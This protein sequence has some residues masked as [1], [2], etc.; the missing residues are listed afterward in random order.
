MEFL[1]QLMAELFTDEPVTGEAINMAEIQ[2]NEVVSVE[3]TEIQ[4]ITEGIV[5]EEP[6]FFSIIQFH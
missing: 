2:Q 1:L 3:D 4:P 6:S 5:V